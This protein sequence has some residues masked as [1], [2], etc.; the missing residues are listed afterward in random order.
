M[1]MDY[2]RFTTLL[3]RIFWLL[4]LLIVSTVVYAD[5]LARQ[6]RRTAKQ[7]EQLMPKIHILQYE[8]SSKRKISIPKEKVCFVIKEIDLVGERT[9][10]FFWLLDYAKDYMSECIGIKG[11]NQLVDFLNEQLT[12]KGYV[13]TRVHLPVQNLKTGLLKLQLFVGTVSEIKKVIVKDSKL[14][15]DRSNWGIWQNAL[16]MQKGDVLNLRPM[17][18]AVENMKRLASQSSTTTKI[19]PGEKENTS[20]VYLLQEPIRLVDRLN[21]G[22]TID[23]SG[24]KSLGRPQFAGYIGIDNAL[25]IND[26]LVYNLNSNVILEH[27]QDSSLGHGFSYGVPYNYFLYNYSFSYN[28]AVNHEKNSNNNIKYRTRSYSHDNK[29]QYLLWRSMSQKVTLYG[30]IKLKKSRRLD[31]FT[32]SG[33]RDTTDAILG[34][35]YRINLANS[36]IS[37]DISFLKGLG[38]F[39]AKLYGKPSK[40][41]RPNLLKYVFN[42]NNNIS[43]NY[44]YSVN[45]MGQHIFYKHVN[46]S[47]QIEIGGRNSVRGFAEDETLLANNGLYV[48]QEI[49]RSWVLK[50]GLQVSPYIALD[51]G[52]VYGGLVTRKNSD[53]WLV[54]SVVGA[55]FTYRYLHSNVAI[56]RNIVKP[57]EFAGGWV[58]QLSL[59]FNV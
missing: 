42:L 18:Q 55:A 44:R 56:G 23:N 28:Q 26:T 8:E 2:F 11:L 1:N 40:E 54:G 45:I 13:T 4:L 17:E 21:A 47:Y 57:K 29:L 32:T 3:K 24:R 43:R 7:Q 6:E 34:A 10:E 33:D 19:E 37:V 9:R 50:N 53:S 15:L 59:S 12:A 5:E 51:F 36:I 46:S 38:I 49:N 48:Q 22:L 41:E 30:N 16:P 39:G 58:M 35:V 25:G 52:R 20:G 27:N 14:E 31:S